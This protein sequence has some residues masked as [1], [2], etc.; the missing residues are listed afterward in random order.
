MIA[1]QQEKEKAAVQAEQ[2][3]IQAE[4]DAEAT[5]IRSEAEANANREIAASLTPELIENNKIEKWSGNLP[6]VQ[7]SGAT[8]IDMKGN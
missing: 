7:G 6:Q 3:R 8:I 4:G 2:K 1:A 5:R